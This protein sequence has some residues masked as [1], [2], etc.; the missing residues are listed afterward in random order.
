[1]RDIASSAYLSILV[2]S[3]YYSLKSHLYITIT[4]YNIHPFHNISV[5][6]ILLQTLTR[7]CVCTRACVILLMFMMHL[8]LNIYLYLY[9][10]HIIL[11]TRSPIL[12]TYITPCVYNINPF[13]NSL[14]YTASASPSLHTYSIQ[15]GINITQFRLCNIEY[16]SRIHEISN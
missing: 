1:M 12:H 9:D 10:M 15:P 14:V 16:P 6:L 13:H 7:A 4:V 2:R 11:V 8:A 5:L 3:A